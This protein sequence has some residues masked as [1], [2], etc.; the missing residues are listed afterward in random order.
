MIENADG[1]TIELS[2]RE[3]PEGD[4]D[5]VDQVL[6][7]VEDQKSPPPKPDP[8]KFELPG[9]ANRTSLPI[10]DQS[11][12]G[13][14]NSCVPSSFAN[15]LLWWDQEGYL[16]I[17]KRG[18]FD[19]KAD[20]IH[21]RLHRFFGTRATAGTNYDDA[22]EGVQ[23]Y[24]EDEMEG[25]ALYASR[26]T[27]DMS[28]ETLAFY[29]NGFRA[30][31][32]EVSIYKDDEYDGGHLVALA[33]ADDNGTVK[34]I[35]WGNKIEGRVSPIDP[36]ERFRQEPSPASVEIEFLNRD[37]LSPWIRNNKIRF[38]VDPM[39]SDSLWMIEPH[40]LKEPQFANAPVPKIPPPSQS[41]TLPLS[42]PSPEPGITPAAAPTQDL[43]EI[44]KPVML[45]KAAP[46]TATPRVWTNEDGKQLRAVLTDVN[47][48][49]NSAQLQAG[50]KSYPIDLDTLSPKDRAYALIW[51]DDSNPSPQSGLSGRLVYQMRDHRKTVV[52]YELVYVRDQ[53]IGK[54]SKTSADPVLKD[55]PSYSGKPDIYHL[56]FS[57]G[58]Y[59]INFAERGKR[60]VGRFASDF[61]RP[62]VELTQF[63]ELNQ[64]ANPV[65]S[66][67]GWPARELEHAPPF[68][69]SARDY[70]AFQVARLRAPAVAAFWR[71]YR[72]GE[73]SPGG[74]AYQFPMSEPFLSA[75]YVLNAIPVEIQARMKAKPEHFAALRL[76]EADF[77]D[78]GPIS[79]QIGSAAAECAP[80]EFK[81]L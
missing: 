43:L 28:P 80:G 24:F 38:I 57:N 81:E 19:D 72:Y 45:E 65:V 70:S 31:L 13:K 25:V 8:A 74:V 44:T 36:E 39:R 9:L 59:Q 34:L 58:T 12:Y 71:F 15:F 69:H 55:S 11:D 50:G 41:L 64:R 16:P 52:T 14:S 66:P 3:V 60:V 54:V 6:E 20:W 32:L 67:G 73:H 42:K 17:D 61:F 37:Q 10:I 29:A 79:L 35:T 4:R 75:A 49:K 53:L 63:I 46:P 7:W 21:D 22:M 77:S 78:P 56:D 23:R 76:M 68:A 62:R 51:A 27:A 40:K 30:T 47:V 2:A 5:W 1:Q 33:E 18:D 26:R 48:V